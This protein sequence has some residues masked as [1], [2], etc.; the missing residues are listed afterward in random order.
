MIASLSLSLSFSFSFSL[1]PYEVNLLLTSILSSLVAVPHPMVDWLCATSL[2]NDCPRNLYSTLQKV[3]AELQSHAG[4]TPGM[5]VSIVEARRRLAG[6]E[7][8]DLLSMP[9]NDLLE[10]A[11]VLEEF[12]K[13]RLYQSIHRIHFSIMHYVSLLHLRMKIYFMYF[14][15][16]RRLLPCSLQRRLHQCSLSHHLNIHYTIFSL[17]FIRTAL[18][19]FHIIIKCAYHEMVPAHSLCFTFILQLKNAL[20]HDIWRDCH[21]LQTRGVGLAFRLRIPAR[22]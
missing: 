10:G 6:Q 4:R 22:D 18:L 14:V 5:I 2:P 15:H 8:S 19:I 21:S 7:T 12:S 1:Q 16:C 3:S 20:N 11:I 13:V 17:I 9:H